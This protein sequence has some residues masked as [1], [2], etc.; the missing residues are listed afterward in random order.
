MLFIQN[1]SSKINVLTEMLLTKKIVLVFYSHM[2]SLSLSLS[3]THTHTQ[4][5]N[6]LFERAR[7]QL[8][9]LLLLLLYGT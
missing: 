8:K 9:L 3:H 2:C 4:P 5:D 7:A 1:R 6:L